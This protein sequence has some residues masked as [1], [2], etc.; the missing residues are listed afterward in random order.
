MT[1]DLL[2]K[3]SFWHCAD[4][5]L[6]DL[7]SFEYHQCRDT[8]DPV[9]HRNTRVRIDVHFHDFELPIVFRGDL[10]DDGSD[11]LTWTAPDR[12]KIHENGGLRVQYF[13]LKITV[14]DCY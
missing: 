13:S 9:L 7:P 3:M 4:D 14:I 1:S 5:L 11:H 6:D 12:P 2:H 8:P 10:L